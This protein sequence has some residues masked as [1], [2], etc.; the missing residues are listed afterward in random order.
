MSLQN[1]P[2]KSFVLLARKW[3]N[4]SITSEEKTLFSDWYNLNQ[5]EPLVL[6]ESK[7][8]DEKEYQNRIFSGIQKRIDQE[9]GKIHVLFYRY[10]TVAAVLLLV[11]GLGIYI[12]V[13]Q[14]HHKSEKPGVA[15]AVNSIG[16]GGDKAYLTLN[17]GSVLKLDEI[18]DGAVREGENLKIRKAQG[19]LIYETFGKAE[20]KFSYNTI[21]TPKGGQFKIILP[22]GT[23]VWLNASS[24]LKYPTHF[25]DGV[26]QVSLSGEGYFEV[27]KL[28]GK[29]GSRGARFVII[30]NEKEKVEVLGTHFNIMAYE[31]EKVIKTTLMEGSVRVSKLGTSH[32]GLLKPGQQS[33]YQEKKGFKIDGSINVD[34]SISWKNGQISFKHAD[35]RSI[36][37]L[38]ERWYNVDVVYQGDIPDRLFSGGISRNS[39]LSELLEVLE[40][41]NIHFT[42]E[43]RTITV[44]Q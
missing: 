28:Q 26:R 12:F 8:H 39:N 13:D 21:T 33:V 15:L 44:T 25:G 3:L 2:P 4:G 10:F 5:D 32:T 18:S 1:R 6:P 31:N 19:T 38:I 43:G 11:C 20:S 7:G 37:R 16:P 24:S 41:N 14:R 23:R 17:D 34:E 22:D 29:P 9:D 30:V 40:L 27:A 35:I 36:M 42:V